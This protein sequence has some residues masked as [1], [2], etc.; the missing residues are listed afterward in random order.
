VWLA[1]DA[2]DLAHRSQLDVALIFSQDHNFSE[3]APIIR[4][5]AAFQNRW[6]KIASAFPG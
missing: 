6:I 3:L 2:T 4:L 5:V 1:L